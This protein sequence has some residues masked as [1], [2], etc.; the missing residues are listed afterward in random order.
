M[1]EVHP[2]ASS[3]YTA[4]VPECKFKKIPEELL[5]IIPVG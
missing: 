1:L 5:I 4:Y 3:A 2:E